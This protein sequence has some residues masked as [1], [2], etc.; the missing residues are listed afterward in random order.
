MLPNLLR[1]IAKV[2]ASFRALLSFLTGLMLLM[3][4]PVHAGAQTAH[5]SSG[6]VNFGTV[7]IGN[8]STANLLTFTFG[9]GGS[10]GKPVA[11]T[12][13]SAA[14]DFALASGGTCQAGTY[15]AGATCT[16]NTTFTPKFAGLRNGAVVL[17][18]GSGDIIATGYVQGIGSGPQV[19]FLP[20]SKYARSN[21]YAAGI[22]VEGSGKIFVA[23]DNSAVKEI[24]PGCIVASCVKTLGGG[25]STPKSVAVDGAGNLFVAD[26]SNNAVKKIPPGCVSSS[27]VKTLGSGFDGPLSVAVDWSGNVFV[28]NY[29]NSAVQEILAAGGYTTVKTLAPAFSFGYPRGVAVDGSGNVFVADTGDNAV[30]EILA[31]GGYTAVNVLGGGFS[32]PNGVAVDGIG[33]VFVADTGHE[34]VKLIPPGCVTSSCVETLASSIGGAGVAVDGSGN[35]FVAALGTWVKLDLADAPSLGFSTPTIIGTTDTAD[36]PHTVTVQNIGN[37][38]LSFPVPT[39]GQNPSISTNFTLNS[40]GESACPLL[41]PASSAAGTL[42]AGASCI[43]PISFAPEAVGKISG[44]LIL[45]DNAVPGTQSITLSGTGLLQTPTIA[46]LGPN[47]LVGGG[48]T[49]LLT[50]NGTNF[51]ANS[52]VDFANT[53]VDFFYMGPTQLVAVVP[54]SLIAEPGAVGVTVTTVSG[55][56]P[57]ATFMVS[58]PLPM[59]TSLSPASATSGGPAF[60]LTI[61]GTYFFSEGVVRWGSTTLTSIVMG[62]NEIAALVPANLIA[63]AGTANVTV[64]T[65]AGTSAAATFTIN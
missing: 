32:E 3:A 6:T 45:T 27:C 22:A 46:S 39:T 17:P 52:D 58:T 61:N 20:G 56:S 49:F 60:I 53:G 47:S 16:V 13:G 50:I 8:T 54:A 21:T 48:P 1:S 34:A 38:P 65:A 29:Y 25:F 15:F 24:S 26:W 11:L 36:G 12:Q 44:S 55:T 35:V 59:I 43:L 42:A 14:L 4:L 51:T 5:L 28:T 23:D 57:A 40:S 37:A 18:D 31:A 63:T 10:I 9:S 2:N 33:N 41:T 30:K 64:T 19:S 7:A 62:P